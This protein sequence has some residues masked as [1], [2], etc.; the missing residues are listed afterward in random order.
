M[1]LLDKSKT[2]VVGVSGG[3]DSMALFT[4]LLKE[5]YSFI[6]A[7]V[8]Y[9]KRKES[10][11]EQAY[12]EKVCKT[13]NIPFFVLSLKEEKEQGNFQAWAREKRY[14]FFKELCIDY[15][16]EGIVVAHHQDDHVETYLLQKE[17]GGLYAHFGL[18][19]LSNYEG[20][21]VIRPLLSFRKKDLEIY[22]KNNDVKYYIDSSNLKDDYK[23]NK[24]RHSVVEK[25]N[26]EEY[27]SILKEI[28]E[29]NDEFNKMQLSAN[30]F[31]L[32]KRTISVEEFA[33]LHKCVQK[34]V[35]FNIFINKKTSLSGDEIEEI[36]NFILSKKESGRLNVSDFCIYKNYG[37]FEILK[38]EEE[39]YKI[40]V[41][42]PCVI[43]TERFYFDLLKG[44]E[45]MFIKDDSYPLNIVHPKKDEIVKIGLINKK[46]N[47]IYIDEKIPLSARNYWPCIK[48]KKG[49]IIF[50]PRTFEGKNENDI[51]FHIN[52]DK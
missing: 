32:C 8:N 1:E 22:C 24:I 50:F 7:F 38:N 19:P 12:V 37:Y 35:I 18:S 44:K 52:M 11:E 21:K 2:Y 28:N 47:R 46:V 17:R 39:E 20:I 49:K 41:D 10:I 51:I 3:P 36:I 48:D 31:L 27:T 5:Q 43:N 25:L 45:Q 34:L 14:K 29:K 16:C 13:N 26:K 9:Y 23:R 33:S 6:V 42:F 15:G 4:M 30:E 40:I